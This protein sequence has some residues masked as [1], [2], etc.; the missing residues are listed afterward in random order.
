MTGTDSIRVT[1]ATNFKIIAAFLVIYVVWGTTF[2]A[3]RIAVE[4]IPAFM[5][6]GLRFVLAGGG[7]LPVLLAQGGRWPSLR[8]WRSAAIGGGLMLAGGIGLLSFAEQR[9]PSGLAALVVA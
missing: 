1:S 8:H 6:A 7:M 3:I 5:M 2:L 4:T 9:I